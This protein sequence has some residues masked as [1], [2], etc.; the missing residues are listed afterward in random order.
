MSIVAGVAEQI[1][2]YRDARGYQL[3]YDTQ[4]TPFEV[5]KE[6]GLA[7]VIG[8]TIDAL[9]GGRT[10][11]DKRGDSKKQRDAKNFLS[12]FI[13]GTQGDTARKTRDEMGGGKITAF[14]DGPRPGEFGFN[15]DTTR[16]VNVPGVTEKAKQKDLER[17]MMGSIAARR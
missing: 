12:K 4:Q 8:G 16:Q 2:A 17:A 10:D 15:F 6:R 1:P 3:G 5:A 11:L 7:G 9:T 13:Y 14:T